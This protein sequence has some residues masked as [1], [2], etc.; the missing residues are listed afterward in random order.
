MNNV[1]DISELQ[2]LTLGA[3]SIKI[4]VLDGPVDLDHP[5]FNVT[6]GNLTPWNH[7]SVKP[8]ASF[9]L[10][11][12]HG[13]AVSSLIFG[14]PGSIVEGVAPGCSGLIIP[15]YSEDERGNYTSASQVGLARAIKTAVDQGANI[16]NISGG[17]YSKY[18]DSEFILKQAIDDCFKAGVLIVA[19]AGNEGCR[20][21]HVPAAEKHVLA[22]GSMDEND[23]PTPETNFGDRYQINGII[24]RGKNLT[25]ALPGGGTFL[26]NGATSYASPIVSGVVGLLMSLQ[27]KN[28]LKPD[29]YVI[30]SLL[31]NL[32]T[33]CAD[34]VQTDCRRFLKGKLNLRKVIDFIQKNHGILA[35]GTEFTNYKII[36]S[37]K[38]TTQNGSEKVSTPSDPKEEQDLSI[39]I[40]MEN[41]DE[42]LKSPEEEQNTTL[43]E[44]HA[45]VADTEISN[46]YLNRPKGE[47]VINPSG[48][49]I[50]FSENN[51]SNNFIKNLNI[52]KMEQNNANENNDIPVLN[53]AVIETVD[54]ESSDMI[55]PSDCGCSTKKSAEPSST[56][57]KLVQP[58]I[59]YALG[60][61]G[62]DFA[63]EAHRDSFTQ[64]MGGANPYDPAAMLQ[65]L[66]KNAHAAEELVWT[67]NIDATPIYA[68]Y[69]TGSH[70]HTGYDFLQKLLED[71]HNGTI[72]RISFPGVS[73]GSTSLLM[74]H[75]VSNL[76]PS[77]R[78][79]F[80]WTTNALVSKVAGAKNADGAVGE[81]VTNFL[82]RVYYQ[83]RN[84]GVV[85]QDRA[86][87]FAATNA[88]QV[89]GV[90]ASAL[91]DSLELHDI[92]VV[93][94][95]IC[96]PG[97]DCYDV[98][99]S[100]FNPKERLTQARKE[101]RFAVDVT[102]IVP[103][104]V[105]ET[106]SWSVY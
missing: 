36:N 28:G 56:A 10:A 106:R 53:G 12:K 7:D 4:A 74:G 77:Q 75:K 44:S 39:N 6:N 68:L 52:T 34:N 82:N 87:N 63:N 11:K 38:Q 50:S 73:K 89:S 35:S 78:G 79:I 70:A 64:S 69:M 98:T 51:N 8:S 62:Y 105:G 67:L 13:T 45:V 85:A 46:E 88:F 96:R 103:V 31:E 42:K 47:S 24:A 58:E 49:E 93:K 91:K 84:L 23:I 60:N 57:T 41:T 95:P 102:H 80:S 48:N 29:A 32:S 83:M 26:T 71:Q 72:Q 104:T 54:L 81:K 16:I 40:S 17:Q 65:F 99:L 14:K 90:F 21:L 9:G 25:A 100:F 61:I 33:P 37:M 59:I 20:C 15:I 18:G 27:I 97:T 101:F 55:T 22:V 43:S 92:A 30:K 94:S 19:A 5:C 66:K 1:L 76:F 3:P 86:L 2:A